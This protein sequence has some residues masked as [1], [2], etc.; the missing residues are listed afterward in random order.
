ML[1]KNTEWLH[2]GL[3]IEISGLVLVK[4]LREV[5]EEKLEGISAGGVS[6]E[7]LWQI[8]YEFFGEIFIKYS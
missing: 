2:E 8:T 1:G 7:K 4:S 5:R 3:P 6:E